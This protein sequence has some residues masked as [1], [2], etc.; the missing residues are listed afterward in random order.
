VNKK[1]PGIERHPRGK[2]KRC[3][4]IKRT[5]DGDRVYVGILSTRGVANAQPVEGSGEDPETV[6]RALALE[7][8][9]DHYYDSR[10]APSRQVFLENSN[11]AQGP[12]KE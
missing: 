5:P 10:D 8:G 7:H 12:E 3:V 9:L 1:L 11:G 2:S 4:S 6:A